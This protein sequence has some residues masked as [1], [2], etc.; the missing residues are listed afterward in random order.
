MAGRFMFVQQTQKLMAQFFDGYESEIY[1]S[2][3]KWLNKHFIFYTLKIK[4]ISNLAPSL[5]QPEFLGRLVSG[6]LTN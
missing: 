2:A 4:G 5:H 6:D 1:N 3:Q